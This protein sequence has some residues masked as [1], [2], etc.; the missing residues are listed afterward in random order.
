MTLLWVKQPRVTINAAD[1]DTIFK[2]TP[3]VGAVAQIQRASFYRF[4]CSDRE[5]G[6]D[7]RDVEVET[8]VNWCRGHTLDS[9]PWNASIHEAIYIIL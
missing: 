9:H 5:C 6:V 7:G 8:A 3:M 2:I 1:G 4:D